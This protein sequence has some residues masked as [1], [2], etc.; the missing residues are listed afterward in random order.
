MTDDYDKS[1]TSAVMPN[2][3]IDMEFTFPSKASP[4][5]SSS[6]KSIPNKGGDVVVR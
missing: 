2:L 4:L 5:L 6:V 3:E 1:C